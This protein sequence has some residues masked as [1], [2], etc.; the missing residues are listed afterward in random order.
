LLDQLAVTGQADSLTS[1]PCLFY[2]EE[3]QVI[4]VSTGLPSLTNETLDGPTQ[5]LISLAHRSFSLANF[6]PSLGVKVKWDV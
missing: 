2:H 4:K 5:F 6:P 1:T 3:Q